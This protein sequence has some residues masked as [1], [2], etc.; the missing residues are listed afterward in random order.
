M[1]AW[2]Q[3]RMSERIKWYFFFFWFCFASTETIRTIRDGEARTATPIFTHLLNSERNRWWR[4]ASCPRMSADILGTNCDQCVSMV[5]CC[6]TSTETV[7]LIRTG[8]PGRPPRLSHSCWTLCR[9]TDR[10]P[11][12]Y[13]STRPRETCNTSP[14]TDTQS[15]THSSRF[16]PQWLT[17]D[18]TLKVS[19]S[20][21]GRSPANQSSRNNALTPNVKEC[22][23]RT[24]KDHT[25]CDHL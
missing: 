21:Q 10:S 20:P 9:E 1:S 19:L 17:A 24:P 13:R 6:F 14:T 8:S 25:L 22:D 3:E 4:R 16:S 23:R 12:V 5:Q 18:R 2:M 7:R 11:H 15:E